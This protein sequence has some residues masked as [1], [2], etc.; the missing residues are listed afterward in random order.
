MIL[1]EEK[2][3]QTIRMLVL[4]SLTFLS[5]F[6]NEVCHYVDAEGARNENSTT[7]KPNDASNSAQ[8]CVRF[9]SGVDEIEPVKKVHDLT[10]SNDDRS[11]SIEELSP[12]VKEEIRNLA[13]TL[14]KSK[15]QESRMSNFQ[16]EPVSLPASRVSSFFRSPASHGQDPPLSR[17]LYS[18]FGCNLPPPVV[19]GVLQPDRPNNGKNVY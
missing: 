11:R 6:T 1:P 10:K 2:E 7:E 8:Q 9:A 14:Q 15:L 4:I 12:E 18:N 19:V 17:A 5:P 13:V 16:Y 3:E